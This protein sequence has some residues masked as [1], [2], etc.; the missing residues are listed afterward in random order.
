MKRSELIKINGEA[1]SADKGGVMQ[2][3][4]TVWAS[5]RNLHLRLLQGVCLM[6]AKLAPARL[7]RC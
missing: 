6:L 5:G 2:P 3:G 7:V 1:V 4:P